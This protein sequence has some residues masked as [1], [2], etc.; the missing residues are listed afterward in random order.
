MQYTPTSP[1]RFKHAVESYADDN[2]EY[3]PFITTDKD[4]SDHDCYL[5]AWGATGYAITGEKEIVALFNGKEESLGDQ[6]VFDALKNGGRW[7]NCF[8]GFLASFYH[9]FGF[10]SVAYLEWDDEQAPDGWD[11][12]RYGRPDVLFMAFNPREGTTGISV[13]EERTWEGAVSRTT[14]YM[15]DP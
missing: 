15:R 4:F 12:E 11:Y 14:T 5:D 8:E 2:P 3:A 7:L 13:T 10:K 1:S 9:D 6:L